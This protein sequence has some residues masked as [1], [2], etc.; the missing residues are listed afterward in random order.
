VSPRDPA[1]EQLLERLDRLHDRMARL[2]GDP[3]AI[4]AETPVDPPPFVLS[5]WTDV[6]RRSAIASLL[7][8]WR[9][10]DLEKQFCIVAVVLCV[11]SAAGMV[12]S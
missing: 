7:D 6:P 3:A 2:A 1:T 11:L 12:L 8:H 5:P 10:L 4:N 9:D